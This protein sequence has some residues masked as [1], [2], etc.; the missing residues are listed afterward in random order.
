M[1][2]ETKTRTIKLNPL[3]ILHY[4][5]IAKYREYDYEVYSALVA[6]GTSLLAEMPLA[7]QEQLVKSDFLLE[8]V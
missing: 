3:D 1:T 4:R 8:D 5:L 6:Q 2:T 7:I